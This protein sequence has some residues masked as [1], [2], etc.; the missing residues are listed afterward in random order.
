M[1]EID[2]NIEGFN[3]NGICVGCL[4]YNRRMFYRDEVKEC[5]MILGDIDVSIAWLL[6]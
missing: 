4:C 1:K 5:F 2:I 6:F 3:V